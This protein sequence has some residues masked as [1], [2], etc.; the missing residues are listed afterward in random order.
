MSEK[1]KQIISLMLDKKE[2]LGVRDDAAMS[3]EE[4]PIPMVFEALITQCKANKGKENAINVS[5]EFILDA[6]AGEVLGEMVAK[7]HLTI[8][9]D[10]ISEFSQTSKNEFL[11]AI[12]QA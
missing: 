3:L 12:H 5:N 9:E 8:S 4:Y 11:A 1:V 2:E 10:T 7:G 6:T